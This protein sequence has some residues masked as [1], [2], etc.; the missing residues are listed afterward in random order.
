M[1]ACRA[2]NGALIHRLIAAHVDMHARND[3]GWTALIEAACYSDLL[4]GKGAARLLTYP[5][6]HQGEQNGL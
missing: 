2:G 5:A 3:E 4:R 1:V 6:P